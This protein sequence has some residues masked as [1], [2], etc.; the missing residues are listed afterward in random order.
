MSGAIS[1]LRSRLCVLWIALPFIAALLVIGC[2]KPPGGSPNSRSKVS[3]GI[4]VSPAM[5][6]LMVAKERGFFEQ[7]GLD[8]N[9]LSAVSFGQYHPVAPNDTPEGRARNRRINIEIQ[10]QVP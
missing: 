5:I 9:Q 1:K 7:Q 4:Q 10:D 8:P 6:L 3:I 2:S